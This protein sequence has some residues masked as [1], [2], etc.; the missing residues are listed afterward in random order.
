V[1][2]NS[3]HLAQTGRESRAVLLL[4]PELVFIELPDAA[5]LFE[6]RTRVLT[7]GSRPSIRLLTSVRRRADVHVKSAL[8]IE[9]NSFVSMLEDAR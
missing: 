2:G 6:E 5:V 8:P 1:P 3:R 7:L 9:R 4:L